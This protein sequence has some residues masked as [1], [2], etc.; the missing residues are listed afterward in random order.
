MCSKSRVSDRF[1]V[2][3]LL[4]HA[5]RTRQPVARLAH[6]DVEN[7]LLDADLP[8]RILLRLRH[9]VGLPSA[10]RKKAQLERLVLRSFFEHDLCKSA[11]ETA[12]GVEAA[13]VSKIPPRP[14]TKPLGVPA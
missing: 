14:K 6:R 7:E 13:L 12:N 4:K 5:C 11:L 8:H 10:D 1:L 2:R 3:E 9:G